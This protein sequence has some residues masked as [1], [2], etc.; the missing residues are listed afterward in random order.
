MSWYVYILE[1]ADASY[2]TGITTDLKRRVNQHNAKKGA[3]SLFGRLP[4]T[5]AYNE[6]CNN[7]IKA[8]KRE[9][10]IKGWR[11]EKKIKLIRSVSEK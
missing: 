6:R 7:Q 2:Y 5:M 9:R 10:E 11:R 4:V 3:K 8:A 1:C